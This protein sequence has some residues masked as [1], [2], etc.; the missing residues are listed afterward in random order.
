[1]SGQSTEPQRRRFGPRAGAAVKEV[2]SGFQVPRHQN[3]VGRIGGD[4]V[5]GISI[6]LAAG[7]PSRCGPLQ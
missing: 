4:E 3:P 2:V 5:L 1:M 6:P 7:T